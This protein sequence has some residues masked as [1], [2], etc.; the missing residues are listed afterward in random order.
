MRWLLTFVIA[1]VGGFAGA[2][3]WSYAG[4]GDEA[5]RTYLMANPEVL[6]KAMEELNR[7]Q[8]S[9]RIGSLRAELELPF[10][11]AVLGNPEGKVTVVEFSDYA[12]GYCRMSVA[13]VKR[14]V[15]ENPDLRVV[16]R[17]Y[18]ILR[19]ESVDAARMALAAA[20]QG[21]YAAFHDA[22]YAIGTPDAKTIAEAAKRA[23]L[24]M[25][26]A[27]AA[28]GSGKFDPFLQSNHQLASQIGISGTPG[29]VIGDQVI[30]G[31]VGHEALASAIAEARQS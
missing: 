22:M 5:T 30:D 13:D 3:V 16:M 23:G 9:V 27:R 29:W 4:F 26:K 28:I 6:P 11:G 2:A 12:C 8:Q 17:E 14:L 18:P 15:K 24:D 20:E 25:D 1:L 10:P 21:K 7:R 19:P 31:A